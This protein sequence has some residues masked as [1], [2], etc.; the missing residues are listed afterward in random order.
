MNEHKWN[1]WRP[2]ETNDVSV[3]SKDQSKHLLNILREA[4]DVKLI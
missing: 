1:A 3:Q 4:K 2:Q